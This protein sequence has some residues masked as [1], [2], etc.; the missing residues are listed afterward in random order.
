MALMDGIIDLLTLL[1]KA[2]PNMK[3]RG[4][5]LRV[6]RVRVWLAPAL[7][8]A[9]SG[10]M[11]LDC[12][13]ASPPNRRTQPSLG[14][15]GGTTR[16][17]A[18]CCRTQRRSSTCPAPR[19][20]TG[21][22]RWRP[23]SARPSRRGSRCVCGELWAVGCQDAWHTPASPPPARCTAAAGPGAGRP[24]CVWREQGVGPDCVHCRVLH[25]IYRCPLAVGTHLFASG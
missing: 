21:P 19:P 1:A 10:P 23:S 18:C 4:R 11:R 9:S 2:F 8:P 5:R 15:S 25:V 16:W 20:H 12:N 24:G 22:T 3:A 13:P 7:V 6:L 17:R 14:A